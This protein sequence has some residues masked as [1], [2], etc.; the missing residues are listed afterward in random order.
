MVR[1]KT[2][3]R[4]NSLSVS[5]DCKSSGLSSVSISSSSNPQL[6]SSSEILCRSDER[7]DRQQQKSQAYGSD[8]RALCRPHPSERPCSSERNTLLVQHPYSWPPSLP[9]TRFWCWVFWLFISSLGVL[10]LEYPGD[11]GLTAGTVLR[12]HSLW[13]TGC[14]MECHGW[15]HSQLCTISPAYWLSSLNSNLGSEQGKVW[16]HHPPSPPS[17]GHKEG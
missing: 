17:L 2:E 5:V 14:H 9:A 1:Q 12:D 3:S 13:C 11:S 7:A 16:P 10:K 6:T 8:H 4:K 15:N